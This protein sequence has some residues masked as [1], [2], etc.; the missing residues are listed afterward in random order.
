M[1]LKGKKQIVGMESRLGVGRGMRRRG[2]GM[3]GESGV[4]KCQLLCLE[5]VSNGVLLYSTRNYVQS[6][7]LEH[8][9][10]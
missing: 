5:W 4:G 8:D 7:G 9:G 10:R 2:S 3:D 1:A 6:F